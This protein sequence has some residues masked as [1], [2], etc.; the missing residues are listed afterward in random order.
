MCVCLILLLQSCFKNST[1]PF[2]SFNIL[3]GSVVGFCDLL[4]CSDSKCRPE[5]PLPLI[6]TGLQ[7]SVHAIFSNIFLTVCDVGC[8]CQ[9]AHTVLHSPTRW[10]NCQNNVSVGCP[11]WV[12]RQAAAPNVGSYGNRFL[13]APSNFGN[14][15]WVQPTLVPH[16]PVPDKRDIMWINT[17]KQKRR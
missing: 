12:W 6:T 17:N 1:S 10:R 13:Y 14:V 8:W 3:L 4:A 9:H 7:C 16:G 15:P 11:R 5:I 2:H